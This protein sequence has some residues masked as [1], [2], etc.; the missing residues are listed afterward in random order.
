VTCVTCGVPVEGCVEEC[1]SCF[2]KT[3]E[4]EFDQFARQTPAPFTPTVPEFQ[5]KHMTTAALA[6][7]NAALMAAHK[8]RTTF[9]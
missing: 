7:A 3:M 4:R 1:G 9:R 2:V 8:E 6:E 5:A